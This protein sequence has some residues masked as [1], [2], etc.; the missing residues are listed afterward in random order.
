M[1]SKPIYLDASQRELLTEIEDLVRA[2]ESAKDA[3]IQAVKQKAQSKKDFAV[4]ISISIM[5]SPDELS[6]ALLRIERELSEQKDAPFADVEYDTIFNDKVTAAFQKGELQAAIEEYVRR[7]NE[8]LAQS[9]YFKKGTFDYYNAAQLAKSLASNGFFSANHT[10]NLKATKGDREITNEK[11][12]EAIIAEEKSY[13]LSDAALRKRFDSVAKQLDK[14]AELRE[15]CNYLQNNEALLAR[16]SNPDRLKQEVLKSYIFV[17]M[18]KY[19]EWMQKH[20]AES[21]RRK[22]LE[23]EAKAKTSRSFT[24]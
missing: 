6:D 3:L 11:E 5:Q 9:T 14:N 16:M 15:F 21:K 19:A 24:C 23:E 8:L 18:D 7:Y 13:I 1:S 4:E 22:E 17:H 10:V 12:L 20:N 2:S